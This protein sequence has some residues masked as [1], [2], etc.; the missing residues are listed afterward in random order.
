MASKIWH[1]LN[2][3]LPLKTVLQLGLDEEIPGGAS[4]FFALGSATLFVFNLQILTGIWQL[5]YYVPT[6]DHAYAS[7]NFLRLSVPY[8]WL[9]HGLHYWGANAMV[10]LIGLHMLRVFIWGAYK[11]P[12][13][14]TWLIGVFLLLLVVGLVFTGAALPWDERGYWAAE[15]GTSIAGTVPFIGNMLI[16]LLRD[17][18]VMGQLVL[19]RFF[20]LHTFILPG[21]AFAIIV[22]HIVS[23]RKYG[24]VGPWQEAKR[25][26]KGNFWPDQ[27][28]KD[29]I[30]S[31]L[32]LLLLVALS[33]YSPPPFTGPADPLDTS[34][35][36]KPEW[37]FLFLYQT[38]KYFTGSLEMLG[39]VGI[40]TLIILLLVF[41]PF[42]DRKKDH[43][44]LKRPIIMTG[45]FV[46]VA[47]ISILTII[48]YNSKPAG[49]QTPKK[50]VKAKVIKLS[51]SA[52]KG[53]KIYETYA[54]F[55]CHKMSGKG[56]KLGPDLT[57]ES[58]KGRSREWIITQLTN[59]KK[60]FPKSIMPPFTMLS[61]QQLN[62][63]TDFI[64]SAHPRT[65][66]AP[67]NRSTSLSNSS[68][69]NAAKSNLKGQ[70]QIK[71]SAS[72]SNNTSKI[73]E[74]EKK[75]GHPGAAAD[76]IGNVEH[77]SLLFK[78]DC[79]S[80]HGVNGK[81]GI[82]NPGSL[83]GKVPRLNPINKE[84]YNKN[85]QTFA[86]NV[87]RIIQHGSIPA[88]T[89][90]ALKMFDYGDSRSL[91]Q[92]EIAHLEAFILDLNGV[93][94]AQIEVSTFTPHQ[95]FIIIAGVFLGVGIILVL[96]GFYVKKKKNE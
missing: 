87:D 15:V 35:A 41:V 75:L 96:V 54:C 36:P 11:K 32:I 94:R 22:V 65:I 2:D 89:N 64:L 56:G 51:P 12:R 46:L 47:F 77:G 58:Q 21:I 61:N 49:S 14:L 23:F 7:L 44:P 6:V 1:W 38:L 72:A 24:S 79:E 81:G 92:Q 90:P 76:I 9:I 42:F 29:L 28:A 5:F 18:E 37:N 86:N 57:N 52:L 50:I 60:H 16:H 30:I 78:H 48:G 43:N 82:P 31:A 40:P 88:G 26:E 66:S 93:N 59:S 4:F 45:G 10:V 80:C 69:N 25:Q 3:R 33:V 67:A 83:T 95:F 84:L 73:I 8:G 20:V 17:G 70:S 27:V 13:E 55:S 19:S 71:K 74:K 34:F 85:P 39:T 62:N 68:S 53:K 91:T 63:L